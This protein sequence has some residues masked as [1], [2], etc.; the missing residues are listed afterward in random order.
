M[1]TV[2]PIANTVVVTGASG[3]LG[4][5]LALRYARDGAVL[6]LLGRDASR[7]AE[8]AEACSSRGAAVS[9]ARI[10]VRAGA[11]MAQ[12][13]ID[14][15]SRTPIDLLIANA[16]VMAG[17][18][19]DAALEQAAAS[20]DVMQTNILG[21]LNSVHPI[22]P[23][24]LARGRGQI[25][26]VSSIAGFIPLPDA[27]SYSASKAALLNY[28]LALRA[29][30]GDAGIGVSVV[31][32]GYIMTPMMDQE[33]GKKPFAMTAEAAAEAIV[34]GLRRNRPVIAFPFLFTLLTRIGGLLPESLRRWTMRP[35]RFSV[36]ARRI[37]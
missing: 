18:A 10:D 3:G 1:S 9:T 16:G 7:L 13:L 2:I 17:R 22:L 32:P 23:R 12:W 19:A 31:C 30:V 8:V 37:G 20:R 5:A 34:R 26:I 21:V 6:G 14:F 36:T 11:D 24:M 15:D 33:S 28:G 35:F 27:P 25:G 4:K 29:A